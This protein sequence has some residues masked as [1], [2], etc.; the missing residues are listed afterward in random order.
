MDI[1]K[2]HD[3]IQIQEFYHGEWRTK[4]VAE[5]RIEARRLIIEYKVNYPSTPFRVKTV[6]IKSE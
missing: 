1:R 4:F 5:N 3:E 2:T 6:R